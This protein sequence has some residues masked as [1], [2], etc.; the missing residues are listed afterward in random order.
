ME[1]KAAIW[2]ST[3]LYILITI[4][5]LGI[6]FAAL[7]PRIDEMRDKAIIEQSI[8]ML[9]KLDETIRVVNEVEGTRKQIDIQLKK[10]TL[11]FECGQGQNK[12]S[13]ESASA[14]KYSELGKKIAIGNLYVLTRETL[15]GYNVTLSL[16]YENEID[17]MF[18]GQNTIK[19]FTSAEVPYT[20]FIENKEG[21]VD[22]YK[23]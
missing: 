11:A 10:G 17:I 6:A 19:R 22:I 14:Y 23:T 5:V 13:W 1:K 7:K 20:F 21:N 3:V 8:E 12:I 9:D 16:E 2:V 4:A 15:G 18:M